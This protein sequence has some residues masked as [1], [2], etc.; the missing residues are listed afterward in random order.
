MVSIKTHEFFGAVQVCIR[1]SLVGFISDNFLNVFCYG[2]NMGGYFNE[3][4]LDHLSLVFEDFFG[5]T[6]TYC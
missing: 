3:N 5:K 6:I 2:A 1:T 4:Y